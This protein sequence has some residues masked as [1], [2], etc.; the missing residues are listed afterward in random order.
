MWIFFDDLSNTLLATYAMLRMS[1]GRY[2]GILTSRVFVVKLGR[3]FAQFPR[4]TQ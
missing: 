3:V 2:I 1:M 4:L